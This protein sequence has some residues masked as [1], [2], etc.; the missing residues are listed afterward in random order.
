M[1]SKLRYYYRKIGS[2]AIL[3]AASIYL[4]VT[5]PSWT[6]GVVFGIALTLF[7]FN[8]M[9]MWSGWMLSRRNRGKS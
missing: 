1:I 7:L 6:T 8:L 5:S 3:F 9:E 4:S 2:S